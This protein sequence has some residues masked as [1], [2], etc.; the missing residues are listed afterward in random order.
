MI[1]NVFYHKM[2]KL[3]IYEDFVVVEVWGQVEEEVAA[4]EDDEIDHRGPVKIGGVL[5][6]VSH[7]FN[8]PLVDFFNFIHNFT[9]PVSSKWL[10]SKAKRNT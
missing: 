4:V 1:L 10:V 9:K 6:V 7:T 8:L 5:W 3:W 2:V